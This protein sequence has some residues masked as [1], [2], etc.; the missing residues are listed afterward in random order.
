MVNVEETPWCSPCQE[1]HREDECPRQDEDS[2]NSM[3]FMDKICNFQEEDVTQEQIN[4]A[5]RKGAREGRLRVL[6]QL[7]DDQRKELRKREFL[8]YTRRNKA[9]VPPSQPSALLAP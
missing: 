7:I 6:K 3:N 9:S 1:P 2:P 5:R 8:T 4:E